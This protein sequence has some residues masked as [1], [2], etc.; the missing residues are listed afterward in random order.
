MN[1]PTSKLGTHYYSELLDVVNVERTHTIEL[2]N[3]I[4]RGN[5]YAEEMRQR[6]LASLESLEK[7]LQK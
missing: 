4:Q 1:P 3:T 2:F 6:F 5:P 7:D